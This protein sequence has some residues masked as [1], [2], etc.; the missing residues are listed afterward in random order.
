MSV[1]KT[2]EPDLAQIHSPWLLSKSAKQKYFML[3]HNTNKWIKHFT[4]HQCTADWQA[5]ILLQWTG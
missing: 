5:F 2:P 1:T 3:R 4:L